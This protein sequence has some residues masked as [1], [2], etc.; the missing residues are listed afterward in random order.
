MCVENTL[1]ILTVVYVGHTGK[2][3]LPENMDRR[4]ELM[5]CLIHIQDID[6]RVFVSMLT[7]LLNGIW[8]LKNVLYAATLY[9]LNCVTRKLY[10]SLRVIPYYVR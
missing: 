6:I 4:Q 8:A 7:E 2:K 9:M 5:T 10:Q 3:K 1:R